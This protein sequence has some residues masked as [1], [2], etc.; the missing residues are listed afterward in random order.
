[1]DIAS[2]HGAVH[3]GAS[4]GHHGDVSGRQGA[5][6]RRPRRVCGSRNDIASRGRRGAGAGRLPD[7]AGRG[8]RGR[9]PADRLHM[10]SRRLGQAGTF[11]AGAGHGDAGRGHAR[12]GAEIDAKGTGVVGSPVAARLGTRASHDRLFQFK[13]AAARATSV[14]S[15]R[16]VRDRGASPITRL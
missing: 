12:G 15:V 1:M 8:E 6:Q 13:A 14:A 4:A 16:L 7:V 9:R 3:R 11:M 5:V 10:G 2:A